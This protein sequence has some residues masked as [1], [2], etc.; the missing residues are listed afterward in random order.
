MV[1]LNKPELSSVQQRYFDLIVS[2]ERASSRKKLQ[3]A[4]QDDNGRIE[5]VCDQL[6]AHC[7]IKISSKWEI[8]LTA[9]GKSIAGVADKTISNK[10]K[11][12]NAI[13]R[14][15]TPKKSAPTV[16]NVT[17]SKPPKMNIK[18][19]TKQ[20]TATA[21]S[22]VSELVE[23]KPIVLGECIDKSLAELERKV[24]N[25][26]VVVKNLDIKVALLERLASFTSDDISE[27]LLSIVNDIKP[28]RL[29]A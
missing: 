15:V 14:L 25:A 12:I 4:T 24:I 7:L 10:N 21:A 29:V 20:A 27:M 23:V 9:Y 28:K 11:K 13:P 2:H 18:A 3:L 8:N 6:K 17:N 26:D 1:N 19:T 16:N 22:L 5:A